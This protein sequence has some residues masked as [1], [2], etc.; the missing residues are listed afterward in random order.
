MILY[1][2]LVSINDAR[3]KK[4]AF[5]NNGNKVN[6]N[7]KKVEKNKDDIEEH[8]LVIRSV[9]CFNGLFE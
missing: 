8:E 7:K 6:E 9:A 3:V 1:Q 2:I 4:K 5:D